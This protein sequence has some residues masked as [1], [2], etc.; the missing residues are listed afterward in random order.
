MW[1]ILARLYGGVYTETQFFETQF[2]LFIFHN[3]F[4][5]KYHFSKIYNRYRIE[6]GSINYFSSRQIEKVKL[7]VEGREN[8]TACQVTEKKRS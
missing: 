4:H 1:E 8:L 5:T 2:I 6:Q 3:N 7:S